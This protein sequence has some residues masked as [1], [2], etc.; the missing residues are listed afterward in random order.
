M[1]LTSAGSHLFGKLSLYVK[2][3]AALRAAGRSPHRRGGAN[4]HSKLRVAAEVR[5]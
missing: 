4:I 5:R 2:E 1:D 3:A